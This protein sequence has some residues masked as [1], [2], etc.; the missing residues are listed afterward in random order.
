[1]KNIIKTKAILSSLLL[2]TFIIV[3]FTGTGLYFSP[4][5]QIAKNT[6]WSFF[7]FDEWQLENIHTRI[8]FIMVALIIIHLFLNYKIFLNEIKN[9]LHR[10]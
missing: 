2:I 10:S 1:M 9:C 5:G 8:G 7:G 4:S 3:T 6:S